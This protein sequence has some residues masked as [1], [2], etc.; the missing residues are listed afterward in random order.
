MSL[1]ISIF[2]GMLLTAVL[3]GAGRLGRLSNY[4]AAVIAAAIPSFAYLVHVV[5]HPV[6]LDTVTLHL[7]AYPT[8]A[9]LLGMINSEKA[10]RQ[11]TGHWAPKL[12]V[13][14]FL[15]VVTMMAGFV[16]IAGQGLPPGLAHLFLPNTQGKDI[17]TG[18]AGVVEHQQDA[19]KGIGQHLG[20]E[21]KLAK[22]GW[23]VEVTGLAELRAGT[24]APVSVRVLDGEGGLVEAVAVALELN[25]P[26]QAAEHRLDLANAGDAYRGTLAGLA[27]GGWVARLRLAKGETKIALE[28]TLEV[29]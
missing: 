1:L 3:Y 23:Q 27:S 29:R 20:M 28:H 15:V 19:A 9:V 5:T 11:G 17:H 25:R 18:F 26:G 6:G 21:D 14:F 4:W 12:L 24:P 22:L 16:Y 7:I 13:G 2:G 10:R 8:V